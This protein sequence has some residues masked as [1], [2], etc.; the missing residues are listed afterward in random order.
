LS[1]EGM[2]LDPKKLEAIWDWKKPIIVKGI[3]SFLGMANFYQKFIKG[4][5]QLLKPLLDLLKKGVILRMEGRVL[6]GVWGLEE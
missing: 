4:F 5:S 3:W 6:K 1:R 2:R